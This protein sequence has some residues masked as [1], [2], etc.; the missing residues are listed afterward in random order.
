M[1]KRSNNNKT[2]KSRRKMQKGGANVNPV[3][4][5][6]LLPISNIALKTTNNILDPKFKVILNNTTHNKIS[7]YADGRLV[8]CI[9]KVDN[10]YYF[11]LNRDLF[12]TFSN[13][14]VIA[15]SYVSSI[16]NDSVTLIKGTYTPVGMFSSEYITINPSASFSYLENKTENN[17]KNKKN[18]NIYD[19]LI[20]WKN[21]NDIKANVVNGAGEAVIIEAG[22]SVCTIM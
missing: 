11:L 5:Q 20:N 21:T 13:K 2:R 17:E 18:K 22:D 3:N 1:T 4:I 19:A 16:T 9:F 10:N 14:F 8:N 6:A 7:I 15:S 12:Q